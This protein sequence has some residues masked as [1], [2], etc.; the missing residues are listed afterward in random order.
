[1]RARILSRAAP[2]A[3]RGLLLEDPV[4]IAPPA[5]PGPSGPRGKY[6]PKTKTAPRGGRRL[7][8]EHTLTRYGAGPSVRARAFAGCI[9]PGA[10]LGAP[11]PPRRPSRGECRCLLPLGA[12]GPSSGLVRPQA[13]GAGALGSRRAPPILENKNGPAGP[14]SSAIPGPFRGACCG[15]PV[16]PPGCGPLYHNFW[17]RF[18]YGYTDTIPTKA[19]GAGGRASSGRIPAGVWY[20]G[21]RRA[22]LLG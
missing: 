20:P 8:V 1:M 2:F 6:F 4:G 15:P 19:R 17:R 5:I 18:G 21:K 7:L 12:G 13:P 3:R 9:Y 11:V 22:G 14:S 10:R 16:T